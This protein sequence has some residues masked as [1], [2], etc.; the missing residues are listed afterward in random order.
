M[1][2]QK[3]VDTAPYCKRIADTP[4]EPPPIMPVSAVVKPI[5]PPTTSNVRVQIRNN[6]RTSSSLQVDTI[7]PMVESRE[8]MHVK[9]LVESK[10]DKENVAQ[11][12]PEFS[13]KSTQ[14][15]TSNSFKRKDVT[16]DAEIPATS[17]PRM[18]PVV[19]HKTSSTDFSTVRTDEKNQQDTLIVNDF[20][21][22]D[23][24]L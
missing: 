17:L 23:A 6:R 11:H 18:T 12:E 10:S 7:Y 1:V 20:S 15:A 4:I 8:I 24:A 14:S 19:H 21:T 5:E 9:S 13:R 3:L 22:K 2:E 16:T